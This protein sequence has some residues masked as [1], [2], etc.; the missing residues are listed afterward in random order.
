[1][2]SGSEGRLYEFIDLYFE[3]DRQI[4]LG[5]AEDI[6]SFFVKLAKVTTKMPPTV[7]PVSTTPG[8]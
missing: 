7:R 2:I 8:D 3:R 6:K 4:R 1:M 5:G